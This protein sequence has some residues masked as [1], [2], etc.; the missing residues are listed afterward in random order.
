LPG[1]RYQSD[2]G[3]LRLAIDENNIRRFD[4]AMGKSMLVQRLKRFS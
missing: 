2:V 4:V 1:R 3:Q